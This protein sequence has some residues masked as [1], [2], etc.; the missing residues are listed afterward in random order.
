MMAAPHRTSRHGAT[1]TAA[2]S[3]IGLALM[4]FGILVA[5]CVPDDPVGCQLEF[6][7]LDADQDGWGD[8]DFAIVACGLEYRFAYY[9]FD[10]DHANPNVNPGAEEVCGNGVDED[11]S[12]ATCPEDGEPES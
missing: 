4:V 10:C 1:V 7:Y 8:S 6:I 12:I 3:R 5:G 9:P 2:S 11:C